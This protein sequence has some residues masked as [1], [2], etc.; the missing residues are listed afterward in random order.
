MTQI[1]AGNE[2]SAAE[3]VFTRTE[4]FRAA[5]ALVTSLT[6][7]GDTWGVYDVLQVARYLETGLTT[8]E[9]GDG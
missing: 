5:H 7:G 9:E 4:V 2:L 3:R 8:R 6:W 1:D